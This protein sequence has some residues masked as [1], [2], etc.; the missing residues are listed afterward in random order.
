MNTTS[1]TLGAILFSGLLSL[2]SIYAGPITFDFSSS[3]YVLGETIIGQQGWTKATIDGPDTD[4]GIVSTSAG[5]M[6]EM[7]S[8]SSGPNYRTS[9]STSFAK[10]AGPEVWVTVNAGWSGSGNAGALISLGGLDY[11][12]PTLINFT[13]DNGI[14]V[15]VGGATVNTLLSYAN[16]KNDG[17][18]YKFEIKLNYADRT[19]DVRLTGTDKN[20]QAINILRQ[21]LAFANGT[22]L[23][24]DGLTGLFISNN[25]GFFKQ[26]YVQS[27]NITN[28]PEPSTSAMLILGGAC[29]LGSRRYWKFSNR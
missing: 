25:G 5:N 4:A 26:T 2:P 23:N 22:P 19:F 13:Q 8:T 17:S 3:P 16:T 1:K 15:T 7:L 11:N 24:A 10:V 29:L 20:D 21:N 14:H 9:V 18:L 6:L 27:I 12:V 28:I